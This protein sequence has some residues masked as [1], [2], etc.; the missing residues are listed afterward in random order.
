MVFSLTSRNRRGEKGFTL[1]E[2][3][4]VISIISLLSSIVLVSLGT[5]RE[6]ARFV[7]MQQ[8]LLSMKNEFEIYH[9]DNGTY[10]TT[11]LI[12]E[13]CYELV[14]GGNYG[15]GEEILTQSME[16]AGFDIADEETT[17]CSV[18]VSDRGYTIAINL[19]NFNSYNSFDNLCMGSFGYFD[20]Q[21]GSEPYDFT[22]PRGSVLDPS[23]ECET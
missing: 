6:R 18:S 17:D 11:P 20:V 15:S 5:A 14:S 22:S 19:R 21:G 8:T 23:G 9:L 1:I 10:R 7:A 13:T 16:L 2:L 12:N 4:V 3:L